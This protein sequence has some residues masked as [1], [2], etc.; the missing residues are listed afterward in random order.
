MWLFV[1]DRDCRGSED[2][3]ESGASKITG[4]WYIA[5]AYTKC[6]HTIE[7]D[8]NNND[9]DNQDVHIGMFECGML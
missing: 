9:D 6:G 5:F 7:E 2:L 4:V 3:F 1:G 8:N